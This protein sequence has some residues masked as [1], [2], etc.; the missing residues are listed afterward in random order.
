MEIERKYLLRQIP[1]DLDRFP[2]SR[3]EQAY[4]CTAPVVRVRQDG[5]S[6]YLTYKSSGMMAREE[7]NLPLTAD[8]YAHLL[9]KAD[10]LI[11]TKVRFRIPLPGGLTA[12]LDRF[13]GALSGLV[14][15]EVEFPDESAANSFCAPDWFGT[16]VT[17][18]P[19]YHNSRM[20][21]GLLP[22]EAKG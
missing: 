13:E 18:D 4:L 5:D 10:G 7:Y 17:F 11:I 16:D 9:A 19:R 12:E 8:S 3:I 22:P 15:A 14:M 21:R 2:H 1:E 20:S 6:F